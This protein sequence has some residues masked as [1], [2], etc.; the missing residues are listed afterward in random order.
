MFWSVGRVFFATSDS[1][2]TYLCDLWRRVRR[3]AVSERG[4]PYDLHPKSDYLQNQ[5]PAGQRLKCG[6]RTDD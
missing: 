5:P 1:R 6:G 3:I 4:R 2:K